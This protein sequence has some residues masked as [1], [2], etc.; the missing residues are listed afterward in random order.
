MGATTI[1]RRVP[2]S[3]VLG[4]LAAMTASIL[5]TAI[6]PT[7][8]AEAASSGEY[9]APDWLPL[10][11][12]HRVGC[13]TG[14]GCDGGY[15]G[16]AAIDFEA[17]RGEAVYA[18]GAGRVIAVRTGGVNCPDDSPPF[19]CAPEQYANTVEIDHGAGVVTRYLHFDTVDVKVN[20]WVD[21]NTRL[22]GAGDSGP[23]TPGFVHLHFEK[24]VDGTKVDAG[25]LRACVGS[26][27][28]G[29][30]T[31]WGASTWSAVPAFSRTVSSNGNTC[32]PASS[33]PARRVPGEPT[34]SADNDL[35]VGAIATDGSLSVRTRTN[36]TWTS[37]GRPTVTLQGT[38][39]FTWADD[40]LYTG[41]VAT[42]GTVWVRTR[43]NASWTA[44][45][46]PG[47]GALGSA[48]LTWADGRL[49]VAAVVTDGSLW[50]RSRS[51]ASD[52]WDTGWSP[53][54]RP[55]VTAI[56][57]SPSL[58]WADGRLFA[59]AIGTDGKLY[60]RSRGDVDNT[61]SAWAT[62]E[63]PTTTVLQGS[64]AVGWAD[65]NLFVVAVAADGTLW[66]RQR[67]DA[68]DTWSVG[69]A[70]LGRPSTTSL[71]A[72]PA[73]A[74]ADGQL[75]VGTIGADGA[76][77]LRGRSA[78]TRTW[79]TAW[80]VLGQPGTP[81]AGSPSL[82]WAGGN[83]H[84]TAVAVGGTLATRSRS[85]A[86]DGW[87]AWTG[88]GRPGAGAASTYRPAT[89]RA[90]G[91][92]GAVMN[93]SASAD[94]GTVTIDWDAPAAGS[95]AATDYLISVSP[96]DTV[97]VVTTTAATLS[98]LPS[99]RVYTV[100]VAART[101]AGVGPWQ[102]SSGAGIG[103]HVATESLLPARLLDTRT[104]PTETTTDGQYQGIGPR[105]AGT[106]TEITIA[107]RGGVPTDATAVMLN[108]TAIT[109]TGPG[110]LTIHPCTT[111]PP[112]ASNLN[113]RTGDI[114]PNAVLA[115]LT[116]TGTICITTSA[117]THI[118]IDVNGYIPAGG[119]PNALTPGR[120]LDTRTGPTETTTDGQYQGIGPRPAGT[121]TEITIAGRGGVPTD[122]TA[123]MLNVTAITPT[124]PGYLTIHPCTTTPP[125]ASNLNYR[126]GDIIP[127]AV[128]AK[129]TPTG[130]ICITTSATT[131][132]AIDVN[133]YIA[134]G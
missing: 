8:P 15:H 53:L 89:A 93:L 56:Q 108:V 60:L 64:P 85:D 11:G 7:P 126:T 106:T 40:N 124:G 75:F 105:P 121:T 129:L 44:L 118:A 37:F 51:D 29:Y 131:H 79:D 92:P 13:T 33:A 81:L 50:V 1:D 9:A 114:I 119:T 32:A 88:L 103:A 117:T 27:L 63:R 14:N 24:Q 95:P 109:P 21:Q 120:L 43:A 86:T 125:L 104:G 66:A 2:R 23:A 34:V 45:G 10:R 128:L 62:L 68:D 36:A 69:W 90:A 47:A 61:W 20:D 91:T 35:L 115:K 70:A 107:G 122:A 67:A 41:A 98:Q 116:P 65:G 83:L 94:D 99:G 84:V 112:L 71:Q 38:P 77:Y 101:T 123:V 42:D 72:S 78:A 18:A 74:A 102:V 111:T 110:Y 31:T 82:A 57:G 134:T 100:A 16:Y 96:G 54:G 133:G 3:L 113:Y 97:G 19:T 26:A 39:S 80:T 30:P 55:T 6:P 25:P 58:T 12:T 5:V 46:K 28:V 49:F 132:I 87:V 52:A 130:T 73:V 76:L 59:T 22:G 127:N 17:V 4:A 48:S